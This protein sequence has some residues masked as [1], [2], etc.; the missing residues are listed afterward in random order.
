MANKE[1]I[2]T[3]QPGR[4]LNL[5]EVTELLRKIVGRW[6]MTA[7]QYQALP[8]ELKDVFAPQIRKLPK[9]G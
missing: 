4:A 5:E 7:E 3:F 8:E 6:E 2:Y 1:T 9:E